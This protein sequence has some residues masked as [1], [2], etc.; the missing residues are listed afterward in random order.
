[1]SLFLIGIVSALVIIFIV[2]SVLI[3]IWLIRKVNLH[4]K[5]IADWDRNLCYNIDEVGRRIDNESIALGTK[6]DEI[7]RHI[8]Q[9][10][11]NLTSYVDKR[12]DKELAKNARPVTALDAAMR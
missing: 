11:N 3:N 12:I 7:Y 5:M 2:A 6:S 4:S 8:D 10:I 1:M 9:S